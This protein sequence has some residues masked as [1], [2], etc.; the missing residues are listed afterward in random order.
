MAHQK[1]HHPGTVW[2][3]SDL[4]CHS[5]RDQAWSG[6]PALPGGDE[7][8][9]EARKAWATEFI[10]ACVKRGIGAVSITDH[11]DVTFV[12]YLIDAAR[13]EFEGT[14]VFPGVEVTC[15]DKTQCLVLFDPTTTPDT[16]GHFLGKLSGISQ[17]P[18]HDPK[19]APTKNANM[20]LHELFADVEGDTRLKDA[21]LILPHFS[22]GNAHKHM[23]E[24]GFHERFATLRCDG[25]Y[26]E[27]SFSE[28]EPVTIEKAYGKIPHWGTRRRAI[29]ATGDNRSPSWDR[30]GTNPCW[31]K[32]GEQSIEALRQALLA[33]EARISYASP[34]IPSERIV[35][36]AVL[37]SLTGSAEMT[38]TFN[39]GF[40]ALIGGRGSG[41]SAIL[42]Y[43]R[44][45]LGRTN[46]DLSGH[47]DDHFDDE[48]DR[49]AQLTGKRA[50][51]FG[52]LGANNG[53]AEIFR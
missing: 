11:H 24:D 42:E 19:T 41:K 23:N 43:L 22:D 12:S 33:D 38:V 4:Q 25:V 2:H 6:P 34:A 27:K 37:S 45:G 46:S 21:C 49:D 15:N 10:K 35:E 3:K 40:N 39:E 5:P 18:P 13:W 31:I 47:G 9:E 52:P 32:L 14:L 29:I 26:I 7:A 44:F 1:G 50:F 16:W 20:T 48:Y 30:L 28:L 36:L 51:L 17:S 8:K 53:R